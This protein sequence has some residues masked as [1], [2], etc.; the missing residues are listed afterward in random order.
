MSHPRNKRERF[1]IGERKGLKR[2][3]GYWNCFPE[4]QDRK[5]AERLT[6]SNARVRRNTTKL[7]SCEICGNPR[8]ARW[9]NKKE[10]LTLQE[11]RFLDVERE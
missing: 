10:K 11:R 1:L 4:I 5:E 7:C 9:T 6:L 3:K 2:S 8:R